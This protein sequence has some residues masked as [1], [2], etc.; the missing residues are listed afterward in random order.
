MLFGGVSFFII[1]PFIQFITKAKRPGRLAK[2]TASGDV[3][4]ADA[5]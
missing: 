3:G 4:C 5:A 1:L 2:A